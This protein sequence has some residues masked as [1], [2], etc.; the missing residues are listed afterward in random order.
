YTLFIDAV[1]DAT[2]LR[3][4]RRM[5]LVLA[6]VMIGA[7]AAIGG[8]ASMIHFALVHHRWVM[9]SLFIGLTL[10]G[11]PIL[12][13]MA[14][15]VRA[16]TRRGI[17]IGAVLMAGLVVVQETGQGGGGMTGTLGFIVG[18]AAAA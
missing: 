9:F 3:F 6:C 4:N 5:L 8:L 10:G 2:R 7:G 11:V 16:D 1:S 18:G 17:V 12:L 15:P 13:R 14:R